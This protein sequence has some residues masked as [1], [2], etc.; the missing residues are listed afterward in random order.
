MSKYVSEDI[1]HS[2]K[3]L[4]R[5]NTTKA[6]ASAQKGVKEK[7]ATKTSTATGSKKSGK[8]GKGKKKSKLTPGGPT[9]QLL[10]AVF[11]KGNKT[12]KIN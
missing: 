9:Q 10:N 3:V 8:T 6:S 11:A 4:R 7:S 5:K 2:Y 12:S 1:Y